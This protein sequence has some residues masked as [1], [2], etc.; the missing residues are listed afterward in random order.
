MRAGQVGCVTNARGFIGRCI[1]AITRSPAH[2]VI[3]GLDADWCV[4]AEPGGTRLRL[5]AEY[6]HVT[7]SAYDHTE[8]QANLIAGLAEYSI[9]T[10]YNYAAIAALAVTHTT[11][12]PIPQPIA[13]WLN[14]RGETTCSQLARDIIRHAADTPNV[15][16]PCPGDWLQFIKEQTCQELS[17]SAPSLAAHT[18]PMVGTAPRTTKRTRQ[19]VA[20]AQH[21]ATAAHTNAQGLAS[22]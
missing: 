1:E 17:A 22:T 10:R 7:W 13:D 12:R 16:V 20:P 6:E 21:A 3:I 9:G 19:S 2:H 8:E 4:S 5:I 11:R 18:S 15:N 14:A